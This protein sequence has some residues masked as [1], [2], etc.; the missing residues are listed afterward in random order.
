LHYAILVVTAAKLLW[1]GLA[2][3]VRA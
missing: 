2:G 1:D 3:Y